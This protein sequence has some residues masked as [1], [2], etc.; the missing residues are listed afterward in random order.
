MF[1]CCLFVAVVA[2]ISVL[3]PTNNKLYRDDDCDDDGYVVVLVA[4]LVKTG[5]RLFI[6]INQK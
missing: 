3:F 2:V 5:E 1:Y 6:Q 4:Y